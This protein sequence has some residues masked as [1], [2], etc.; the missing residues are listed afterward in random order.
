MPKLKI[1]DLEKI[2]EKVKRSTILRDGG[3]NRA[4]VIVHM[5]TCGILS[6][7]REVM[8]AL[9]ME[10]EK[11]NVTDVIAK[12]SGCAGLCSKEPMITVELVNQSPVKYIYVNP[13]KMSKIF[14]EHVLGGKIV[15]EY[16]LAHG[17]ESTDKA[18]R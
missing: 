12:A 10:I 9:L 7:A 6:G 18:Q 4:K 1:D 2:K 16:A 14:K 13:E 15:E 5:S 17:S 8:N 3:E 11:N